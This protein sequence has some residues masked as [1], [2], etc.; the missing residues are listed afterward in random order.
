[1]QPASVAVATDLSAVSQSTPS[2]IPDPERS[3]SRALLIACLTVALERF[4]FYVV[5][6]LYPHEQWAKLNQLN[7]M[8]LQSPIAITDKERESLLEILESYESTK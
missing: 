4:A 7:L 3:R 8:S 1:M 6:S 5:F 2:P